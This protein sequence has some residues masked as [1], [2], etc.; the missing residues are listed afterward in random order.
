METVVLTREANGNVNE[1][2]GFQNIVN[3]LALAAS[4]HTL[5]QT[6]VESNRSISPKGTVRMYARASCWR[7]EVF[8]STMRRTMTHFDGASFLL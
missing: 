8:A 3:S 4:Q 6:R 1:S 2:G 5:T 7:E